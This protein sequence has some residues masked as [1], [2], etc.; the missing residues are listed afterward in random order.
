MLLYNKS[1]ILGRILCSNYF[2]VVKIT[3]CSSL[4]SFYLFIF[5]WRAVLLLLRSLHLKYQD[6]ILTLFL[7]SASGVGVEPT[8]RRVKAILHYHNATPIWSRI[9]PAYEMIFSSLHFSSYHFWYSWV[10]SFLFLSQ[11]KI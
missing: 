1:I 7:F 5:I 8:F 10:Y 4:T 3:S 9:S 2:Y 6:T 11:K